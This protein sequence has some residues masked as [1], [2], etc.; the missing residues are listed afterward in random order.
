MP[1]GGTKQIESDVSVTSHDATTFDDFI[2]S[3][4][5]YDKR[6]PEFRDK[7]LEIRKKKT[8]KAPKK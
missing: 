4:Q 8:K 1:N 5:M 3:V 7:S 6:T 2:N